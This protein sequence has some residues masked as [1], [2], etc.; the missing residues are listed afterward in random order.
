MNGIDNSS[1]C[2]W[3]MRSGGNTIERKDEVVVVLDE[4]G[5]RDVFVRGPASIGPPVDLFDLDARFGPELRPAEDSHLSERFR[6]Y[7]KFERDSLPTDE[8]RG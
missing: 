4:Q 5:K 1:P 6:N 3:E 8:G 2:A 7:D